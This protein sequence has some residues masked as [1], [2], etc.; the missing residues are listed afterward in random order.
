M[1]PLFSILHTSAR[2]DQWRKIYDAWIAAAVNPEQVEYALCVDER[3]GFKRE[4]QVSPDLIAWYES[5]YLMGLERNIV[6][7]NQGRRCYVDGVNTAAKASTGRILIVNAD[8]QYPCE[9]W[10]EKLAYRILQHDQVQMVQKQAAE[11]RAVYS[12][13]GFFLPVGAEYLRNALTACAQDFDFVVEVSTGT[14]DEHA[15]RIMV[16][17]ILSRARYERLGYVF[18]PEYESMFADN[19]FCEH[20]Q[21]DGV[22]ID[23]R[24]LMFPHK[25]YGFDSGG[26]LHEDERQKRLDDV[27][28]AQN[29]PEAYVIGEHILKYRRKILFGKV[30]DEAEKIQGWMSRAELEWLSRAAYESGSVIEVGSW[31]G[32]S[33]LAIAL[34]TDGPVHVVDTW[35]G[36]PELPAMQAE[37]AD[38]KVF[39]EFRKNAGA[40]VTMHRGD[41]VAQA[42]GLPTVGMVF[43]DGG[44]TYEQKKADLLAYMPKATKLI[45]GHDF[46]DPHVRQAVVEL[47]GDPQIVPGTRL[48]FYRLPEGHQFEVKPKEQRTIALCISGESFH[49]EWVHALLKLHTYLGV[50]GFMVWTGREYTSNV[51]VTREQIRKVMLEQDP[52][53]DLFLWMDDDNPAPSP[54]QFDLLLKDLEDHPEIDGITGW[55]WIYNTQTGVMHPSCGMAS[56]DGLRWRP[57]NPVFFPRETA[58]RL[59]EQTGFPCFLMKLSALE[60]AGHRPFL[61]IIDESFDHGLSGED[62]GFCM[63]AQANGAVFM[64]DPRVR[65]QHLKITDAVPNVP[66]VLRLADPKI[67]VMMRVKN[68]ARWIGRCINSVIPLA[69]EN[70]F[71]MDDEST[72]DTLEIARGLGVNVYSDPFPGEPLDET[73]DKEWLL[74]QVKAACDPDW[75]LCID[76]DEELEPDGATMIREVLQTANPDVDVFALNFLFLW[77]SVDQIR[78]DGRFS[79]LGR[80]SLFRAKGTGIHFKSYYEVDLNGTHNPNDPKCHVGLHCGNAPVMDGKKSPINVNLLH[81]GYIL[82]EDR[83]RKY[84]WYRSIDPDN[85]YEDNYRHIVL[86]DL[87]EL[88][89]TLKLPLGGPLKLVK[90]TP[91]MVPKFAKPL[92]PLKDGPGREDSNLLGAT[93]VQAIN[94]EPRCSPPSR[95]AETES[96]LSEVLL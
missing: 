63:R 83:I 78:V 75:I 70:V 94:L 8:D 85:P 27:Y 15:R 51:Y 74:T 62:L 45:C 52:K 18:Y 6:R 95:P 7:W 65:V 56:P 42:A 37:A 19:E 13:D 39:Q 93:P 89:A 55:C 73:R 88:P 59:V 96:S 10:D 40:L 36:S 49:W 57:F 67:A 72:D 69:G 87:P 2:P 33:T 71:V 41:S 92:E 17:P 23:A 66:E 54:E 81:Y 30:L 91:R 76:G 82:R 29:R 53:P 32:R 14:P 3:W 20:A 50:K 26:W 9:G 44:H 31:K 21:Q 5:R 4:P 58:P 90:L 16:M 22:V 86:G 77:D 84:N 47:L 43:L 11:G 38:N 1:Q 79:S 64:V 61:P 25:H 80:E 60:K 35:D 46:P 34:S 24:H 28:V 12:G 48:W 68:E